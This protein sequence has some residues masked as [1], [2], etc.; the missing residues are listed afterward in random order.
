L[1]L[2]FSALCCSDANQTIYG[3]WTFVPEEGTDIVTW[4]YRQQE[5]EV[6][7]NDG[8][9]AVLHYFYYRKKVAYIDSMIF[10][11]SGDQSISKQTT[12]NWAGNWYMGVLTQVGSAKKVSGKWQQEHKVLQVERE[13]L[14]Q[15]SQGEKLLNTTL[16]YRVEGNRLIVVEQRSTRPTPVKLVFKEKVAE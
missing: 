8:E 5:L 6:S 10:M 14:L 16:E 7:N 1:L 15:T 13:D 3:R 12:P 4:R 2:V 11:P 9:I